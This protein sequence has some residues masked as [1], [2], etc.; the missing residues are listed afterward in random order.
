MLPLLVNVMFLYGLL[1][2]VCGIPLM[3]FALASAVRYLE[4]P[5]RRRGV[6]L[7]VLAVALFYAHVVPYALFGVGYAALFPW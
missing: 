6:L 1:P 7:G 5:S 2:F 4:R 3:L